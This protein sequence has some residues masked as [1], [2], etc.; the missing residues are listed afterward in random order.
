MPKY[1]DR[2]WS[3]YKK[4]WEDVRDLYGEGKKTKKNCQHMF[5]NLLQM[6]VVFLPLDLEVWHFKIL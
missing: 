3:S 2:G 6:Y 5:F 1:M 4:A